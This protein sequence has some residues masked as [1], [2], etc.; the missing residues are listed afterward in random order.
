[1]ALYK[2]NSGTL[3]IHTTNTFTGST[4]VSNGTLLVHG[5]LDQSAV[6]VRNSG[7]L[8]GTGRF[9]N[10][11]TVH[12]GGLIAPGD[13]AA[14]AGVLTITNGLTQSGGAR[15]RF[16]LSDDPG[17]TNDRAE[18]IGNL[19][20]S[21]INTLEMNLLNGPL[22]NGDYVLFNYSGTFFREPGQLNCR[23]R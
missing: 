23:W 12:A 3:T 17:G 22:A 4:I 5:S 21:G 9:G 18:V 6:T 8:G 10:G 1:M 16:D 11:V 13:G 7:T 15:N 19:T 14:N 20:L 2:T